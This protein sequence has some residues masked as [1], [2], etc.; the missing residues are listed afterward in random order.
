MKYLLP[1]L[2]SLLFLSCKD[3]KDPAADT[4]SF[5]ALSFIRSQVRD[6]DTSLYHIRKISEEPGHSDTTVIS[7]EEFRKEAAPFLNMPDISSD[8]LR[9]DYTENKYFDETLNKVVLFYT[10]K[11][12]EAPLQRQQVY[13]DPDEGGG[14]VK[15]IIIDIYENK[16][17]FSAHRNLIWSSNSHFQISENYPGPGGTERIRRTK[18]FWNDFPS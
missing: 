1:G 3:K 15:T 12:A 13:I 16:N 17:G 2:L 8:E 9:D 14:L 7:R 6:V 11:N 10:A 5:P 4:Q 18:V